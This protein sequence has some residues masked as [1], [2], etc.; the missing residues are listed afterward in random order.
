[1]PPELLGDTGKLRD[2]RSSLPYALLDLITLPYGFDFSSLYRVQNIQVVGNLS[3]QPIQ[4]SEN[5][6]L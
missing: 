2:A 1:M 4:I 6:T 5:T 3:R